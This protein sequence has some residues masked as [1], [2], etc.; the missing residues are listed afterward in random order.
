MNV[1]DRLMTQGGETAEAASKGVVA[2][3]PASLSNLGPGFDAIGLCLGGLGDR[4]EVWRSDREAGSVHILPTDDPLQASV[5]DDPARNTAAVAAAAVLRKAGADVGVTLRIDKGIDVG[6]GVGSSSASA[7][8]GA[9]ATNVLLDRPFDKQA[10]VEAV[11][12]GEQVAS[13]SLHGDNVL[14]ALFGGLVLVSA[15]DPADYRCL[16]LPGE[17]P[18]ALLQPDLH[19]YTKQARA[20]LPDK[21]SLLDAVHNASALARMIDAFHAGDWKEVGRLIM[22]D[23]IVE[24]LRAGLVPCYEAVRHAAMDAGALGC[25]LTGSGPAMFALAET[26][27]AAETVKEAMAAACRAEKIE[28][29]ACVTQAD[30]DGVRCLEDD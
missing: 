18:I 3:G 12:E 26:V 24:P 6:S 8:A 19:V 27:Q 10:L 25:A 13:G 4:V 28:A 15:S 7:V 29:S 5:P 30:P 22:A 9:W 16:R 14:P 1:Q 2:W 11:L 20:M 23:R 21:V 17:L